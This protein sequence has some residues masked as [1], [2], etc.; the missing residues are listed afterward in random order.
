MRWS[1]VT[2]VPTIWISILQ[3]AIRYICGSSKRRTKH[4]VIVLFI[5]YPN[6]SKNPIRHPRSDRVVVPRILV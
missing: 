5:M 3:K 1:M 4:T 2:V 6:P